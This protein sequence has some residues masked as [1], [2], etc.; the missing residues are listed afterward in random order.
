M[1]ILYPLLIALIITIPL[2]IFSPSLL[3]QTDDSN[4]KSVVKLP[5]GYSPT[6]MDLIDD[7]VTID[8]YDNYNIGTDFGEPYI[9]TNPKD[10]KNSICAF[11]I[12]SIYYTINGT[13]WI[14]TL[15]TFPG[16]S[17]L[18]DPVLAFDSLGVCYYVQLYQNGGTYGICVMKSFDKGVTWTNSVSAFSTTVGLADKEWIYADYTG[19]PFSNNVYIGWRQFGSTGMRFVRSTNGGTSWSSP[20]TFTGNQGAYVCVGPNGSVQGGSVYFASLNSNSILVTRSTDGG[21]TFG[22]QINATGT[23]APGGTPCAGRQT[24]KGCIRMDSF[25]RMAADNSYTASRGNAY[26]VTVINPEGPD[27]AD[28]YLYRSTNNGLNWSTGLRVNDD[29]TT[30][31]QWL[32]AVTVDKK[33]GKVFVCWYDSRIDPVNNKRTLIY[34]TVST[35]GGVSFLSNDPI[36]NKD[37]DPDSMRVVQPGSHYYIGDY[38]GNSPIEN[39]SYN[40]WMD[41]RNRTLGSYT[42]Y[43]PDYAVIANTSSMNVSTGETRTVTLKV[44]SK[45]GPFNETVKFTAVLDTLPTSG[46]I[47]LSF[48]NN[49]DSVTTIPDSVRL[50]ISV[51]GSVPAK[52]YTVIIFARGVNGTPSHSRKVELLV[53]ASRLTVATNRST[54]VPYQVN[55]NNYTTPQEFIFSNGSNVNLNAPLSFLAGSGN[56]V[57]LNWSNAGPA[58]QN[59]TINGNTDLFASY[60]IQYKLLVNSAYGFVTGNNQ[61]FDSASNAT[62]TVTQRVINVGGTNYYFR[63]WTGGGPGSYTSAD[64]LGRDTIVNHPINNP[65]VETA[66]WSTEPA[67]VIT[68]SSEI[69]MEYSLYQNYPNPF[70]PQT[71]IRFDIVKTGNVRIILYDITGKEVK[72]V[73][74]ESKQPGKYETVFDASGLASG[75]YYYKIISN[76][77]VDVKKMIFIK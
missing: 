8:G 58:N 11:N 57:F 44:P 25:P 12:N 6:I 61:Y 55:G 39:T 68:I 41:G 20:L 27:I 3:A 46:T 32:P 65:Y 5:E 17:V 69:P 36:S 2:S 23:F 14:R 50:N 40:V 45:K 76:G 59:I 73:I 10:P 29:N 38:I 15:A 72:T 35:N 22:T 54:I 33:T 67:G 49:K 31:D 13:D 48:V 21:V 26:I 74:N 4:L 75:I 34:G 70:N 1:K 66:R 7:P 37:F 30:T 53:N 43:Y 56:Y 77:F 60:K 71:K 18:G 24:V 63:G 51:N 16:F 9:A 42:G 62:F 52:K 19:G 28:I 64:S 47:G